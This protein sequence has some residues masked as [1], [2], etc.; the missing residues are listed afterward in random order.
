MKYCCCNASSVE[1]FAT[2][3]ELSTEFRSLFDADAKHE[4]LAVF[5]IGSEFQLGHDAQ[6][7]RLGQTDFT[8]LQ[9]ERKACGLECN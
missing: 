7:E 9:D 5:L 1:L 4:I 2:G 8:S 3:A 6:Y